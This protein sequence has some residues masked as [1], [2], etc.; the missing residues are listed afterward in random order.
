VDGRTVPVSDHRTRRVVRHR[1][2]H[3]DFIG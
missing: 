3:S 2:T 1:A